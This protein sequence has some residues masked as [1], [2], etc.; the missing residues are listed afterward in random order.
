MSEAAAI[1]VGGGVIGAAILHALAKRGVP[2]LLLEQGEV[3]GGATGP[4][5]GIL[6]ALDL[7]EQHCE[8]AAASFPRFLRFEQEVGEPCGYRRTGLLYFV[9]QADR[10]RLERRVA[11]VRE[12]GCALDVLEP[13]EGAR[14]FPHFDWSG[15]DA[16]V[17]EPFAGHADPVRATRAWLRAAQAAGARV[18]E[19]TRVERLLVEAGRAVGV[20]TAG[21]ELRARAVV[22]AAGAWSAPLL[23]PLGIALDV[24]SK[25]IQVTRCAWPA[26][27]TTYPGFIDTTT[28]LY[29]RAD[30]DGSFL[31]GLPTANWDVDLDAF[32]A[33][34]RHARAVLAR[35][36]A[37]MPCVRDGAQAGIVAGF[38]GYTPDRR[39]IVGPC[40]EL[41]GLL[42]AVGFSGG[43]FK[44]APEVGR[45]I[46]EG[47]ASA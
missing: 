15:I 27:F 30:V 21:G 12:L 4:S 35:A 3:A 33:D 20:A 47:V 26:H 37:R 6:R 38:D 41:R 43:G 5:V 10:E 9:A 44:Q 23:A 18:R 28:A 42:L 1:V 13:Q 46:A 2:A 7:D 24:R 36:P 39:A 31:V 22:L 29:G 19:R 32:T 25:E 14:R 11:R 40:A 16:A 45:R 17:L 8:L 34:E